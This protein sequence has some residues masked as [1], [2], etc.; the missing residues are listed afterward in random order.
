M[1]EDQN[2]YERVWE[3][4]HKTALAMKDDGITDSNVPLAIADFLIIN[5][6]AMTHQEGTGPIAV[7]ALLARQI[8]LLDDWC[9]GN[10][11]FEEDDFNGKELFKNKEN[12]TTH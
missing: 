6:L 7:H 4:L 9:N 1:K 2:D 3:H 12:L 11:P 5:T 8:R 10:A